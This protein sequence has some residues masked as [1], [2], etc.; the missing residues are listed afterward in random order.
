MKFKKLISKSLAIGLFL[1]SSMISFAGIL[2]DDGRYETFEGDY[3][4]ID[5]VLEEGSVELDEIQG[6]TMVNYAQNGDKEL[7]LNGDIDL[8][9]TSVTTTEGVDSGLVDVE[10]EGNTLVN[11][12]SYNKFPFILNGSGGQTIIKDD[13]KISNP[14]DEYT[15]ILSLSNVQNNNNPLLIDFSGGTGSP[16]ISI[17]P[18]NGLN[19]LLVTN[20]VST[21]DLWIYFLE[22]DIASATVDSIL[23]LEGDWTDKEI[24]PYF[25]GIKSVGE[26]EGNKIEV[27]SSNS[28]NTKSNKKEILLNEP[29]RGLS[30]GVKDRFVK[31]D[32]KWYIERNCIEVVLDGSET[33]HSFPED[34]S[35]GVVRWWTTPRIE[36]KI[37]QRP[38]VN[39][40]YNTGTL[41]ESYNFLC[42][43]ANGN[44]L[45]GISKDI[46]STQ[47]T[48]AFKEWLS[49]N[50]TTVVYQLETPI[51][52]ELEIEPTL[53][54]Y[55]DV[56]NISNN[57]TI[58]ANMKVKNSGYD[59]I[60]KPNTTYTVAVDTDKSGTIEMDLGGAKGETNN[61]VLTL[62][63]PEILVNNLLRLYGE[64]IKISNIRVLEGDVPDNIPTYFEGIQSSFENNIQNNDTYKMEITSNNKNLFDYK[65][66]DFNRIIIK[67]EDDKYVIPENSIKH[68]ITSSA[69]NVRPNTTYTIK[70]E[71]ND[72]Y[73][74]NG[75]YPIRWAVA[76]K[77]DIQYDLDRDSVIAYAYQ[78][79]R[80]T[81][82]TNANTQNIYIAF[83]TDGI[84]EETGRPRI[85]FKVHLEETSNSIEYSSHQSN[86]VQISLNEPLRA[87]GDVKDRI[88]KRNG[89]WMVERNIG[90]IELNGDEPW[91]IED[92]EGELSSSSSE[93]Y[94]LNISN[95]SNIN[96]NYTNF[97]KKATILT[98]RYYTFTL[99]EI[100]FTDLVGIGCSSN[101]LSIRENFADMEEFKSKLKNNPLKLI[102][103]LENPTYEPLNIGLDLYTY[104]DVT[105]ISNNSNIP[106]NMKITYD[107]TINRATEAIELAKTNPTVENL[108]QARYWSNLLKEST[109]KDEL[110]N[111]IN[112]IN[113]IEDFQLERKTATSNVDIYVKS[114]NMLL[115]S[116]STNHITFND[117]SGVEDVTLDN[118]I[119][120]SI[121]SSLPYQLNSYLVSEI[122]NSD[123]S[124]SIDKSLFN[125]K[126]N[127]DNTYKQ[128]NNINEKLVL[129]DDCES[130]NNKIHNIDLM[131]EGGD[132]H[133]ADIYKTTIKFEAEQK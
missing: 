92:T 97:N 106:T 103:E 65:N 31:K 130:G 67:E 105:H 66:I 63:T 58:P 44:F 41:T 124:Q 90:S 107:R 36:A 38:I 40:V 93:R 85:E 73:P 12:F 27:I 20:K 11:R 72:I 118:A 100:L 113:N 57:S 56:T 88:I 42:I 71:G 128:F 54:I 132:A 15:F 47:D 131:L 98:D 104:L 119:N 48:V 84:Y 122:Q 75:I 9:G 61:N 102:Y 16:S 4:T 37:N 77:I 117:Y 23:I 5:N 6:N 49:Q 101:F 19:K 22:D 43:D 52:E 18:K 30:N 99:N 115:M 79:D 108:S 28:D 29:L 33:W 74:S 10:V 39:N 55:S 59:C 87:V 51:Y 60:L 68:W 109:L 25:E 17:F 1:N 121:N 35:N 64:G 91:Q 125:I 62:T 76:D 32:G 80:V 14:N 81:F 95:I 96:L 110:Q 13:F 126:D 83:C 34:E 2:S 89:Q 50:P 24:P 94:L 3:I 69:I 8:E 112:D 7:I 127:V 78:Y 21:N 129:K 45:Y 46:I 120:I 86:N 114:E 123:G 70:L 26:L 133:I 116:L 111:E 82:T 53:N